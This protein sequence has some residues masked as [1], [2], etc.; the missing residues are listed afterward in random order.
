MASIILIVHGQCK[1][2]EPSELFFSTG[3]VFMIPAN[4]IVQLH[5]GIEFLELF[6]AFV[7]L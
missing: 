4:T 7:N 2:E 3:K 6:Q 5:V 1:I